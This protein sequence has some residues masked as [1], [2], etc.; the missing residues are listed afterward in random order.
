MQ[1]SLEAGLGISREVAFVSDTGGTD[2]VVPVALAPAAVVT[3]KGFGGG[4]ADSWVV[5][6]FEGASVVDFSWDDNDD[7]VT[8]DGVD[9]V[10]LD[11]VTWD[12][13]LAVFSAVVVGEDE[14]VD[15]LMMVAVA[16]INA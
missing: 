5:V 10:P 1:A 9:V 7:V 14:V 4:V 2:F 3:D 15:S 8:G 12:G 13:I 6:T 16:G 11:V